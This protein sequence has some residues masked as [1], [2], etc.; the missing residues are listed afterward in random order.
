MF[1]DFHFESILWLWGALLIPMVW[2]LYALLYRKRNST[3]HLDDFIDE[4]L[5]PHL[6]LNKDAVNQSI[7]KSI[8]LWSVLWALLMMALAGPRWDFAEIEVYKSDQSL[9]ILL[10]LSQS[11]DAEDEKPSRIARAK[12]EIEDILHYAQ[13][14]RIALIVFAADPHM[15]NPLTD[16]ME[17]IRHLL[18]S[19]ET[20]LIYIQ[21][22]RLSPAFDM[23]YRMLSSEPG[24]NKSILVMSDGGFEDASAI[25]TARKLAS[26]GI[27]I[28]T[29][30]LGSLDGA[31]VKDSKNNFIKKNGSMIISRLEDDKLKAVSRTGGGQYLKAEYH[32]RDS[33]TILDQ[34]ALRAEAEQVMQS[35]T[36]HWEEQFY[37][38]ILP[39]LAMFL[40]W[41]RKGFVFPAILLFLC[42]PVEHTHAEVL[43]YF[44]NNPQKGKN[45]LER[46]DYNTAI[47]KF[48]DPYR[49]GVVH[50]NAGNFLEAEEA[51]K[52]SF[53]PE[54]AEDAT[55]NLGNA[56]ARQQKYNEAIQV[57]ESLLEQNPDHKKARH[58]LEIVKKLLEQQ[59]QDQSQGDDQENKNGNK[60]DQGNSD[61]SDQNNKTEQPEDGH[62]DNQG[63]ENSE[64]QESSEQEGSEAKTSEEDRI[65]EQQKNMDSGSTEQLEENRSQRTQQDI[66]ADQWLNRITNDPESFLKNQFYI[67]SRQRGTKEGS[68]PW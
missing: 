51:F 4:H 18:P 57:W 13:G 10:D 8:L 60:Q 36:R 6:V 39:V 16:D 56:L 15:I 29:M 59:Q 33:R 20:D 35:T 2:L 68:D 9:V 1:R 45:A 19:L 52:K 47:Q 49:Q 41:F 62:Q 44:I 31:P 37:L 46:G 53:R 12:Q 54:I 11:M 14:V 27:I 50:Y 38:L 65:K 34:L 23:A 61:P 7:W 43:D 22:S 26:S 21:G 5:L 55:Y 67:E 32:D 24:N 66:D 25:A 58:N 40:F 17:S 42:M 28:H 48:K 64:N 63:G 3:Y 30:G